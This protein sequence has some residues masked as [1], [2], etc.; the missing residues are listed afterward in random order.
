[1]PTSKRKAHLLRRLK[2]A[3][4]PTRIV[5]VDTETKPHVVSDG[6][7]QNILW[8]G[9]AV[10]MRRHS[11]GGWSDPQWFRFTTV[12]AFW[13]WV[14]DLVP[15]KTALYMFAHNL[16]FDEQV[17][18][19]FTEMDD[20]DWRLD[21]AILE[22]PPSIL[23][24][25][26]G[27]RKVIFLDS[28]N[29]FLMSLERL[30]VELGIEKLDMPSYEDSP[31]DWDTYCRRDVEVLIRA[32]LEWFDRITTWE[33]GGFKYTIASQAFTAFRHR[34]LNHKIFIHT[35]E[36]A[37]ALE[38]ESYYGGRT[39]AFFIGKVDEPLKV[40]DVNSMYPHVMSAE[41]F[42]RWY[43][44]TEQAMSLYDLDRTLPDYA[45]V[46][47]CLVETDEPVYPVRY[48]NKLIFP[49]GR[50][51]T[52]LSTPE[53][54]YARKHNHILRTYAVSVYDQAPIFADYVRDM[55]A[56]REEAKR[57]DDTIQNL[58]TKLLL[59]SLYG[60]FGQRGFTWDST[61]ADVPGDVGIWK[62]FNLD[63][64]EYETFRVI[65]GNVF[66]EKRANEAH[67][68]F[69]AIAAHVTAAA[70]IKMWEA[71]KLVGNRN[72]FYCDTDSMVLNQSGFEIMK[73]HLDPTELGAWSLDYET[74]TGEFYGA[75]DYIIGDRRKMKGIRW[76]AIEIAS[77]VYEQDMFRKITGGL[78]RG[79][80][81][82]QLVIRIRKRLA[83]HYDK[84]V[85]GPDG[86]VSP[87]TLPLSS[88][89]DA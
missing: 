78:R 29:W 23:Q 37:L 65:K 5:I 17:L 22:E 39:E 67:N 50:F 16:S 7:T 89:S 47:D 45:V 56:R 9:W 62:V 10:Y 53:V 83:R 19:G 76:N 82:R 35:D 31:Q 79:E 28:L 54:R 14:E 25:T 73:P 24:W 3:P 43:L 44:S 52:V 12:T 72:V 70:R 85:V 8:F 13:D 49:T 88:E 21:L 69:P 30:G 59:N 27:K 32:L 58:H 84:G 40:I 33:L 68:S 2:A 20:R 34:Y 26:K 6:V 66:M 61:D 48:N 1:M 18:M 81:D 87:I 64:R 42:P 71:L 75:K 4:L 51:R 11:H 77:G 86:W 55:Y 46:V 36:H 74:E 63:T 15:E 80:V 60:K 41:Q 57:T 38:R